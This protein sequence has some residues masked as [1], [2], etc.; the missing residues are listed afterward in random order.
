MGNSP[1][2]VGTHREGV[3]FNPHTPPLD[4]RSGLTEG[5]R[6]TR[7]ITQ[8]PTRRVTLLRWGNL[9]RP[10]IG[11]A[12]TS[13]AATVWAPHNEKF[14]Y[15]GFRIGSFNAGEPSSV[16]NIP[17]IMEIPFMAQLNGKHGIRTTSNKMLAVAHFREN[18]TAFRTLYIARV[19]QI[20][21]RK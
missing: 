19:A 7:K 18:E 13:A 20:F 17:P 2:A 8:P 15:G 5:A 12:R 9:K 1:F 14:R 3:F 10:P 16:N 21:H 11:G 6:P 4:V